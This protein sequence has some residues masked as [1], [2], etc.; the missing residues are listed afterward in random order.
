VLSLSFLERKVKNRTLQTAESAAPVVTTGAPMKSIGMQKT[1][2]PSKLP[3]FLR[4]SR[5]NKQRPYIGRAWSE[6]L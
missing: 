2:S 3:S 6:S 4:A 1:H 5:V